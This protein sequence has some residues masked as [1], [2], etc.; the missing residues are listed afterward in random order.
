MALSGA[1]TAVALVGGT[2]VAVTQASSE[3][4]QPLVNVAAAGTADDRTPT[5]PPPPKKPKPSAAPKTTAVPPGPRPTV[6]GRS[7]SGRLGPWEN[8][9]RRISSVA[10]IRA[11]VR[12]DGVFMF[13]DSIAVQ[14]GPALE[15]LVAAQTGT[16]VAVHD[17]SGQPASAG[18][19]ALADWSRKYG[20]PDR[21]VM[22]VGTND[23]FAPAAFATEVEQAMK[24]AGPKRTVYWVNVHANRWGLSAAVQSA[25]RANS[26]LIN[27]ALDQA[28]A[29]HPNLHVV[30]WSEFLSARSGQVTK[31]LRDGIHTTQ[32]TGQRARN[33]LIA[34]ALGSAE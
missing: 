5:P 21:I 26:A 28:A 8:L 13:G 23:I 30:R 33:A 6:A 29:R 3:V 15:Q 14:D 16:P 12:G 11:T 34:Q 10:K 17:W 1:L 9:S 4:E 19:D 20:L 18:V 22:A 25:D 31:Y 7:G 2:A 24:I 27:K 32:P